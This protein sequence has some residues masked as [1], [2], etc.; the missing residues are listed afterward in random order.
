MLFALLVPLFMVITG[1][2]LYIAYQQ[3]LERG[4]VARMTAQLY[5]LLAVLEPRADGVWMPEQLLDERFNQP[6]SGLFAQINARSRERLWRSA[7]ALGIAGPERG[8]LPNAPLG[9]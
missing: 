4:Y 7:S 8:V 9:R 3:S 5:G 6:Q 2:V 1:G